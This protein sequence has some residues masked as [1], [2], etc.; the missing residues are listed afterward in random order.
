LPSGPPWVNPGPE[1]PIPSEFGALL[2][3]PHDDKRPIFIGHYWL[4]PERPAP[5][6]PTI[7]CLDYSVAAG[8]PLV[9]YRWDG[10]R[11][12]R[13]DKFVF[14][15]TRLHRCAETDTPVAVS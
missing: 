5:L 11:H 13:P 2:T 1:I 4:P 3:P 10:E 9:A 15:P 6:T 7:A 14:D 12:L 8:G